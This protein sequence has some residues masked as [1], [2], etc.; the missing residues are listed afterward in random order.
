MAADS[1]SD[2]ALLTM[3]ANGD[4]DAFAALVRRHNPRFYKTAFLMMSSSDDAEEIVQEAFLK[5]W[6]KPQS[7]NPDKG[8]KFTTWFA[9]IIMNLCH[10]MFRKRRVVIMSEVTEYLAD[11]ATK[12]DENAAMK[13]Q[14][15]ALERAIQSLPHH[16]KAALTLCF[17]GGHSVNDAAEIL[18]IGPKALESLLMR[19]KAKLKDQLIRNGITKKE[20]HN[21]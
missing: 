16:Q 12:P 13:E 20:I 1:R 3:I 14:N 21:G 9:R 6:R 11:N 15:R 10:D 8:A 4:H 7:W 2:E 19:A 17:Y 5:L 18:Q